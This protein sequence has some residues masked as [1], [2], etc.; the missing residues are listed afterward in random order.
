MNDFLPTDYN[1]PAPTYLTQGVYLA[2]IKEIKRN[3]DKLGEPVVDR[4]GN[5]SLNITLVDQKS[6]GIFIDRMSFGTKKVQWLLDGLMKAIGVDNK[7]RTPSVSEA[8]GKEV[9][10]VVEEVRYVTEDGE[11]LQRDDGK[12]KIYYNRK[13]YYKVIDRHTPPVLAPEE[14]ERDYVAET[15]VVTAEAPQGKTVIDYEPGDKVAF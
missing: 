11:I 9:F 3:L 12:P 15:P 7:G 8:I 1:T 4:G 13:R 5:H 10:L 2:K 6:G 14:M